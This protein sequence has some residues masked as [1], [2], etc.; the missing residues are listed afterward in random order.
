MRKI[1]FRAK[2]NIG[3]ENL[4]EIEI[5]HYRN[6]V[7]GTY[8]DGFIVDG[9]AEATDEYIALEFWCPIDI[10]TVGQ[11]TGLK[12]RNGVEIYEGDV[13]KGYS[14]YPTIST[15]ESVLMGEV[16]YT[17]RGTWD[18][19]SYILGGFNKQVEVIGNIHENPEL[20]ESEE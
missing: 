14:V 17:N 12:D 18:C 6:W 16:Y 5:E 4:E 10:D 15:F 20:L 9:V 7:F 2:T 1:K 8:L 13:V 19:C 11:Y 3:I